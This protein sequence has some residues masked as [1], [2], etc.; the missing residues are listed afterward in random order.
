MSLYQ[1]LISTHSS[2]LYE[3]SSYRIGFV[4][5]TERFEDACRPFGAE[6]QL[7]KCASRGADQ[8]TRIVRSAEGGS[9]TPPTSPLRDGPANTVWTS[10]RRARPVKWPGNVGAPH[11]RRPRC[12]V[13]DTYT[14]SA[15][16]F[17]CVRA[18]RDRYTV[19][20]T[21]GLTFRFF[22]VPTP[23]AGRPLASPPPVR[24]FMKR[25]RVAGFTRSRA[26]L[27]CR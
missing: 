2:N 5:F 17:T 16:P 14:T 25:E 6:R 23:S 13:R 4:M 3:Q 9:E 26:R 20:R 1:K 7:V 24:R 11:V 18:N 19:V 27:S 22:L 21:K 10:V 8:R 12:G 15:Y